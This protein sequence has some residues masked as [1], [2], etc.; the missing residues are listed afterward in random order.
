MMNDADQQGDTAEREQDVAED[1]DEAELL[2][3]RALDVA[4]A[5]STRNA[6]GEVR[7]AASI[8]AHELGRR[9]AVLGPHADRVTGPG[10]RGWPAPC[11]CRR[12]DGGAGRADVG[13]LHEPGDPV[14][15]GGMARRDAD[16]VAD[17]EVRVGRGEAVDRDLA[18]VRTSGPRRG[19][20]HQARGRDGQ[21]ELRR[22]VD[23]ERLAVAVD[24]VGGAL[25]GA[26]DRGD[27][28]DP[29]GSRRRGSPARPGGAVSRSAERTAGLPLTITS[30]PRSAWVN[31]LSKPRVAVE[32]STSVAH[33]MA[34]PNTIASAVRMVRSLRDAMP[35]SARRFSR[36]LHA[37]EDLARGEVRLLRD[38]EAVG[39]EDDAVGT[40]AAMASCVTI[41]IAWPRSSAALRSRPRT[42]VEARESR[43]PVGSSANTIAGR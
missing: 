24:E 31:Q 43:L 35:R 8:A 4:C 13:E 39:E 5:V 30:E 34:V 41:A 40:A 10:G 2:V 37:V 26:A 14:A 27:A 20:G 11:Q 36:V 7:C 21:A 16:A 19:A 1:V 12:R 6:T 25:D 28:G 3:H 29:G 42:S 23:A 22:A 32:V 9:D 33:T 38:D 18:R 15:L 17:A